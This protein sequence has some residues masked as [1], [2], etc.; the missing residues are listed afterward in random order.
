[1]SPTSL[2]IVSAPRE[3]SGA[4]RSARAG[5]DSML[6]ARRDPISRDRRRSMLLPS[7]SPRGARTKS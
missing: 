3:R 4:E 6:F 1:M 5:G 7:R 2:R